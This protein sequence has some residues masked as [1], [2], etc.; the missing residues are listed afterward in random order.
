MVLRMSGVC[1][2]I[3]PSLCYPTM[4]NTGGG[5][6][7]VKALHMQ[8]ESSADHLAYLVPLRASL[9]RRWGRRGC[10]DEFW[11]RYQASPTFVTFLERGLVYYTRNCFISSRSSSVGV[12]IALPVHLIIFSFCLLLLERWRRTSQG[13]QHPSSCVLKRLAKPSCIYYG[14]H[15]LFEGTVQ[16]L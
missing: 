5:G 6:L 10:G 9:R 12:S 4:C 7:K 2:Y 16:I 8:A 15:H 14:W 3:S 1:I 13:E 11:S